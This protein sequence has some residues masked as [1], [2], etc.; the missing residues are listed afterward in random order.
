MS[1]ARNAN[2]ATYAAAGAPTYLGISIHAIRRLIAARAITVPQ[3]EPG[4]R[5]WFLRSEL[6]A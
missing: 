3:A 4:A 5:C 2:P 6:D 1:A